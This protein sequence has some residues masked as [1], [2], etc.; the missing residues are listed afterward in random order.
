MCTHTNQNEAA[1]L[2]LTKV[3]DGSFVNDA[4][5]LSISAQSGTAAGSSIAPSTTI[6]TSLL[7]VSGEDV[8]L[9][10]VFT[11]GNA[12]DYEICLLYTSPSPRDQRGSRMPSS[13]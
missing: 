12:S 6:S 11:T 1:T 3:W 8:T 5:D 9:G 13:A 10:E 2:T 7:V 4:V